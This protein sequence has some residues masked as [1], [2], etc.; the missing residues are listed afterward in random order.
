MALKKIQTNIDLLL[1]QISQYEEVA[2][3][4][5]AVSTSDTDFIKMWHSFND[6]RDKLI[7]IDPDFFA[8][9]QKLPEPPVESF[10]SGL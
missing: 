7:K 2:Y 9:I 1:E 8:D 10:R 4:P 5:G 6:Q 3:L